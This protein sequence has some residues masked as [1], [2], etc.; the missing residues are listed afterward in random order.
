MLSTKQ[1]WTRYSGTTC[2]KPRSRSSNEATSL[3]LAMVSLLK[4]E[5]A[6]RELTHNVAAVAHEEVAARFAFDIHVFPC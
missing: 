2:A 1:A 4:A 6:Y 3:Q 5:W